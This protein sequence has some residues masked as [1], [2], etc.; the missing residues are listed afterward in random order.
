[1]KVAQ[2]SQVRKFPYDVV[3][4]IAS[5]EAKSEDVRHALPDIIESKRSEEVS[6]CLA[7]I[8]ESSEDG[9]IGKRLEGNIAS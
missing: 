9:L 4:M 3:T 6:S 7:A 5:G 1:V 2:R 8:A